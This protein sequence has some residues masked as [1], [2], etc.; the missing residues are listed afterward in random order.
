MRL[1]AT[2]WERSMCKKARASGT[3]IRGRFL[4][5]GLG[6]SISVGKI[7]PPRFYFFTYNNVFNTSYLMG[8]T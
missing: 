7:L 8:L 3:Y 4:V 1:R 6:R 5:A 2:A